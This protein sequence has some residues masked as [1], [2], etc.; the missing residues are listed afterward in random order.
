MAPLA[1][2]N[3][4][5]RWYF[6]YITGNDAAKARAHTAMLRTAFDSPV[7]VSEIQDKFLNLLNQLGA[8]AFRAGWRVTG[9]RQSTANTDFS[10]PVPVTTNLAA[11]VGTGSYTGWVISSEAIE[12]R[13]VGRSPLTG[14]KGSFSLYGEA[15]NSIAD[16]RASTSES[17]GTANVV[18]ALN[19]AST[20]RLVVGD[21]TVATWYA[22]ANLNYNSHWESALRT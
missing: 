15:N 1:A 10:V 4:T 16:F 3:L 13:F 7:S 2:Y 17:T 9:V 22:Y 18:A 11:F 8:P 14:V 6:D 5:T 20:P 21:N 19:A 12:R